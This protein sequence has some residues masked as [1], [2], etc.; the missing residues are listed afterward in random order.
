MNRTTKMGYQYVTHFCHDF[1]QNLPDRQELWCENRGGYDPDLQHFHPN[2][3]LNHVAFETK[4]EGSGDL[5]REI[6]FYIGLDA[7]TQNIA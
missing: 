2:A 1:P 5:A 3:L 6:P 7:L 4:V